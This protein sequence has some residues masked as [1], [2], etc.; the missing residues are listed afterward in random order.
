MNA[1]IYT[2]IFPLLRRL[3]LGLVL[4][5]A[6]FASTAQAQTQTL[7]MNGFPGTIGNAF[8]KAFM[9]TYD[10][11]VNIRYVESWDSARFTQMQAN[12]ARPRD[13]V[14]MFTDLTL[15]L[16]A[17][18][19][20]L[21]PFN[22]AIVTALADVDPAVRVAG[23]VGVPYGYGC[24]G[25]A[26]NAKYVKNPPQSWAD[27]LKDEFKGHVS[28]PNIS[29]S[30][31]FNVMDGLSKTRGKSLHNPQDAMEMYRQIRQSGPG[32]WDG[33]N[34][35]IGWLKTG[36]IWVTPYHSGNTLA[37]A[38]DP[39][40]ADIR[41]IVPKEG[42]YYAPLAVAKVKNGPNGGDVTDRFVNHVLDPANQEVYA[43]LNQVRPVNMKAK[44]PPQVAAACPTA[45]E[46]NK[47][48]IEYM[49]LNRGKIIDQWNQIVNR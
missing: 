45:S 20:L 22:P 44:I 36:E 2:R 7:N 6:T 30:A 29:Y 39:D 37:L 49:N 16:V 31:A 47:I 34:M 12:R 15:P 25:I 43:Q 9:E 40:L 46:L 23:D 32:L 41:F 28:G 4:A 10:K 27:L 1:H 24:F 35:A 3:G 42:A 5:G 19:G 8:R 38:M 18:A 17:A 48:D 11:R 13:D 26:Y 33:E 14:V 21:E